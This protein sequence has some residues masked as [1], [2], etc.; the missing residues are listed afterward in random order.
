MIVDIAELLGL[1]IMGVGIAMMHAPSAI[2]FAGF[3]ILG[4]CFAYRRKGQQ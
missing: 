3:A 4:C 2:I 1:I